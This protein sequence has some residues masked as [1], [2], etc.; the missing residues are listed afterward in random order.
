MRSHYNHSTSSKGKTQSTNFIEQ[1]INP[2]Y[3]ERK[4]FILML[5]GSTEGADRH[6]QEAYNRGFPEDRQIIVERDGTTFDN[7]MDYFQHAYRRPYRGRIIYGDLLGVAR[8]LLSR[9]VPVRD[10]DLDHCCHYGQ[11]EPELYQ[12]VLDYRIPSFSTT[13]NTRGGSKIIE[14]LGRKYGL[15]KKPPMRGDGSLIGGLDQGLVRHPR[16][17]AKDYTLAD[18]TAWF[19]EHPEYY[20]PPMR[21]Y[22]GAG[23]TCMG[24]VVGHLRDMDSE[25]TGPMRTTI[26]KK[27]TWP[28]SL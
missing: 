4:G 13:F 22:R 18:T 6:V 19:K 28:P 20:V 16:Y 15:S 10:I 8:D 26:R 23:Q 7:L 9:G 24:T 12:L 3:Y 1:H 21:G 11:Q 17:V 14:T 2:G 25:W 5:V 27:L